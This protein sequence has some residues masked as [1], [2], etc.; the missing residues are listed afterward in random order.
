MSALFGGISG[1][2]TSRRRFGLPPAIIMLTVFVLTAAALAVWLMLP[3]Q[4]II[5]RVGAV[6]FSPDGRFLAAGNRQGG[7]VIWRLDSFHPLSRIRLNEAGLNALAFS[8]DARL[9]AVAGRSLQLW[10]TANWKEVTELGTAG[11]VYGT[12]RFSSDGRLLASVNASE[13]IEIWDTLTRKRVQTLCCMALYGDVSFS[14]DGGVLAA[15]GHWPCLW[16]RSTGRRI[17][18]LVETR[19]PTFGAVLF[20]PDGRV[21][22]TGSQDGKARLWEVATGRELLSTKPRRNY[23][24]TVAFHPDGRLLAYGIRD[25]AVWLWDTAAN[26]ERMI[27]PVTTSNASFSPDGRWLGFGVPGGSVHL[28]DV[29]NGR[30]GPVLPLAQD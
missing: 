4:E 14:P 19:D 5:P 16:D 10:S 20:R 22:A 30:D 26:S 28:W 29:M 9:L 8:P 21:I 27:A 2:P 7:I 1:G 13:R 23:I 17:R 11:S 25:G 24:E 12:A 6:A 18:R 3:R 15:G